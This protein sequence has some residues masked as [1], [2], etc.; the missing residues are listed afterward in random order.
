M[1]V[2]QPE[3]EGEDRGGG[4]TGHRLLTVAL[5]GGAVALLSR[6]DV[7]NRVLDLLF[8]AEE[9]FNY[10]SLTD[11][12]MPAADHS[13]SEPW[14][15]ASEP[16]AEPEA[17]PQ[18]GS[19]DLS[20]EDPGDEPA[21]PTRLTSIAP[22]PADWRAAETPAPDSPAPA[23]DVNGGSA[24]ASW[25]SPVQGRNGGAGTHA[26]ERR[27]AAAAPPSPPPGW[28]SPSKPAVGPTDG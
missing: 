16:A 17:G 9:E 27:T 23:P 11:P 2:D 4:R 20:S 12:P 21:S 7:R 22:S 10:S 26:S 15:R 14:V 28:W 3:A 13:P 19:A 25:S 8:G 5:L 6:E 18:D 24:T 1:A